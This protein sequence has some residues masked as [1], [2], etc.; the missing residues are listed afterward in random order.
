MAS[1]L[2]THFDDRVYE[3]KFTTRARP[4]FSILIYP[5]VS[6]DESFTHMG[7][8]RNLIGETPDYETVVKFSNEKQVNEN[9]PPT[10]LVHST[11]DRA[12]P[13]ENS[14]HYYLSLKN[15]CVP[16]E[17]HIYENGGHGYGL[18]TDT[19]HNSWPIACE[20]WLK[21]HKFISSNESVIH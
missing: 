9:T 10:F 11:D 14:I 2:S 1:T 16:A 6:F 20:L 21:E 17:M 15:Y 8:R 18:G 5:V 7:S 13:V 4:D 12:V 3:S 19:T